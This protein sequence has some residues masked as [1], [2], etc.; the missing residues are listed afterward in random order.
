MATIATQGNRASD[1]YP[2]GQTLLEV[3]FETF[4]NS[5]VTT[6]ASGVTIGIDESGAVDSGTGTPLA[7]TS[8]GIIER[9]NGLFTYP[10][11]CPA[12]TPPGSYLV[13]WTGTRASDGQTVTYTQAVNVAADPVSVPLPGVYASVQQ[14]RNWSGDNATPSQRVQVCLQRAT[15]QID[16]ALIAA[17]Y[18]TDADGMPQDA[19]LANALM[20][21][22]SAQA[23]YIIAINDDANLK[24]E[25]A[26][27]SAGGVSVSRA[28]AGQSM[29]LPP[30][31]PQAL[32]ILHVVGI[33]PASPLIHW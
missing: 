29:A 27:I 3:Q 8:S 23:Q 28:Q 1:V 31:C 32:A 25:Y 10:W 5:G 9:G 7:P 2:G 33:L 6:G 12:A 15:E 13:T 17:V 22:T 21:A 16:H 20:R 30:I 24:R 4:I 19:M 11:L 26:S 18:R 14:Y